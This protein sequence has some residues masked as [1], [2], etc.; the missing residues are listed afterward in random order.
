MCSVSSLLLV[1][2]AIKGTALLLV[3]AMTALVLRRDSAATR[4]YVWLVAM[5]A[6][7]GLPVLSPFLPQWRVLPGWAGL[8]S[9]P[10]I[11]NTSQT[12]APKPLEAAVDIPRDDVSI[13]V[14]PPNAIPY[15]PPAEQTTSVV[16]T[17]SS[18]L[19]LLT[20]LHALPWIWAIGFFGLILR[21]MAARWILSRCESRS[22]VVWPSKQSVSIR[23]DPLVMAIK[24]VCLQLQI[25]HP[26]TLL[27]HPEKT[28]PIVWGI[29]RSRLLLPVAARQWDGE[30]LRSVLLHELAHIKRLDPL[31]HLLARRSLAL[32]N[33]ST[34]LF[35]SLPGV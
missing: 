31:T 27:I 30:Q 19:V 18:P 17:V 7:L 5:V 35:G 24:S 3:A 14:E 13:K 22:T 29:F 6:L 16:P 9:N 11:E 26:I 23:N 32:S 15:R 10:V 1:D 4:H 33:G 25:R 8:P 28:I 20:W 2:S 34:R 21:L 12:S